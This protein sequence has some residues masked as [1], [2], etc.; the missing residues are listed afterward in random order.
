MQVGIGDASGM[1]TDGSETCRLVYLESEVVGG[2]CGAPDRFLN[3][4]H[5]GK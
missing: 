4:S 5:G 3:I 2:D 1:V